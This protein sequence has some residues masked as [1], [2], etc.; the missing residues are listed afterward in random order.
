MNIINSLL[1]IS[2][3]R[4]KEAPG[5]GIK[6][7]SGVDV[8]IYILRGELIYADRLDSIVEASIIIFASRHESISGFKT[9]S[10]HTPGNWTDEAKFGGLPMELCISPANI[11]TNMVKLLNEYKPEEWYA[12]YE[13][14]HHGPY[15]ESIPT[16]F[17]EIGSTEREWRQKEAGEI[18]ASVILESLRRGSQKPAAV[19]FGGPHYAPSITKYV[20]E[21]GDIAIGHIASRYVIDRLTQDIVSKAFER[22]LEDAD[23]AVIDRK[24]LKKRHRDKLIPWFKEL[25]KEVLEI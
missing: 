16:V 2:S 7:Y 13:V 23:I 5:E 4:E 25:G 22:T 21:E 3:F 18:I 12:T 9:L 1:E 8:D 11:L 10:A 24:G 14:T 6:Y 20:V 15:I 19:A 17:I